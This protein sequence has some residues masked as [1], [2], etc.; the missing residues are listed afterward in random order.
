MVAA[1]H[2]GNAR[3]TRVLVCRLQQQQRVVQQA[4]AALGPRLAREESQRRRP[5]PDAVAEPEQADE[6]KGVQ[7]P[8]SDAIVTGRHA[9]EHADDEELVKNGKLRR[10]VAPRHSEALEGVRHLDGRR[11]LH[12]RLERVAPVTREPTQQ[13]RL[14]RKN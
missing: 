5:E 9:L 3:E 8:L 11:G 10:D 2:L 13:H 12:L 1:A 4:L 6:A 14:H 7:Q